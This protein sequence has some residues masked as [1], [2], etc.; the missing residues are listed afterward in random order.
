MFVE[1]LKHSTSR[2]NLAS[3]NTGYNFL[4]SFFGGGSTTKNGIAVNSNSA[5]TLSAFYNGVT[6]LANDIAKL[7]KSVYQKQGRDSR[8]ATEH[9]ANYLIAKRPNEYMT[10]FMFHFALTLDAILKGNGLAEIVEDNFTGNPVSYNLIDQDVTPVTI[11]KY[12]NKLWYLFDG[13]TVAAENILHIPGFSFNGITGVGVVKHAANT[14]GVALENQAFAQE[15]YATKGVGLGVV[16]S[17]KDLDTPQKT[18]Y[19]NAL[20]ENLTAKSSKGFGVAVLDQ[21]GSFQH[22]K[23][24]PQEA[25]FLQTNQMAIGEVARILNI[26]VYKL[27]DTQNQNNSNM[28]HQSIGHVSDSILPWKIKFEQEYDYKLFS[29]AQKQDG[30]YT[31]FNTNVL[32]LADKKTQAEY[33]KSLWNIGAMTTDEVRNKED[34]PFIEGTD[35][36]FFQVNT[37]TLEQVNLNTAIKQKELNANQNE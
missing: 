37:Q 25:M 14:L 12:D 10:S 5:L 18:A 15:Y 1:A 21:M 22:I 4:S 26:P 6:I 8:K 23:I 7:P 13:R 27:K 20:S 17:A 34:L 33:Y 24:T 30:Y 32:L 28:E 31:K 29:S 19:A 2:R 35:Q 3:L 16:T 9:P 11:K 36:P